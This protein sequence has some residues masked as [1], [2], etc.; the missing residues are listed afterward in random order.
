MKL[1]DLNDNLYNDPVRVEFNR[2]VSPRYLRLGVSFDTSG[3]DVH[4]GQFAHLQVTDASDPLLRR[5]FSF[6]DVWTEDNRVRADFL[7]AVV[8]KGTREMSRLSEGDQLKLMGPLG[9]PFTP[10]AKNVHPVLIG[11]GVGIPPIHM[12]ARQLCEQNA[13]QQPIDVLMGARSAEEVMCEADFDQPGIRLHISTDDGS[14]GFEGV[15]TELFK[16]LDRQNQFP[17]P[18]KLYGC[19]PHGMLEAIRQMTVEGNLSAEIAI[20]RQMGCALGICRACVVK[21]RNPETGQNDVKT[22]CREGPV[23]DVDRLC[24]DW[25]AE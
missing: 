13:S 10:P 15:V 11:G 18:I 19:G 22:V 21:V 4:P 24:P 2:S 9:N 1:P 5:P 25:N 23:F 8:G 16:D 3:F 6:H 20:E 14:R 12:F 7:Y 17:S